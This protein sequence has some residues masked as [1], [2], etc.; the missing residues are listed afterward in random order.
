MTRRE[1]TLLAVILASA[2]VLGGIAWGGARL[3]SARRAAESAAATLAECERIARRIEAARAP[4]EASPGQAGTPQ[5]ARL[6]AAAE[7]A[8]ELPEGTIA[9]I[10]PGPPRR[11]GDGPF[12]EHSTRVEL[13]GVD[14]RQL[15]TFL[16]ALAAA[17]KEGRGVGLKDIR[18]TAAAPGDGPA[19]AWSVDGTLTHTSYEPK[20]AQPMR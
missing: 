15:F 1:R 16:H 12:L 2:G 13:R 8:A 14:L 10:E 4:A 5:M 17:A 11:L 20:V 7:E 9:R 3:G 18:L 6:I 19:E